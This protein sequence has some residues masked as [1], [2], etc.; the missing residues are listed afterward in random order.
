MPVLQSYKNDAQAVFFVDPPYT[1]GGKSAGK[2]LY[3]YFELNHQKLFESC[4][5]LSGDFLMT[6]D[7]ALEVH[8]LVH[9][10]SLSSKLIPMKNT[11]HAPMTELVIG[12]DLS[13]L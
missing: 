4:S 8:D 5:Q 6:Y 11:H 7:D 13:W 10:H 2:R 1:A 9:Q 3:A 12:R